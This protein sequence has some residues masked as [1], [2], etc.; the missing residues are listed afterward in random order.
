MV[1]RLSKLYRQRIVNVN[2]N[3]VLAGML[4]LAPTL[5]IVHL[6][7]TFGFTEKLARLLG[8]EREFAINAIT[9]LGDVVCDVGIYYGLHWLANHWPRKATETLH[10]PQPHPVHP[11]FFK[12]A[13]MVQVERMTLSPFLYLLFLGTQHLLIVR[14]VDPVAATAIGAGIG[15]TATRILHTLWMVRQ[16]RRAARRYAASLAA[17]PAVRCPECDRDL[18]AQAGGTCPGCGGRVSGLGG[19]V[20]GVGSGAGV[21]VKGVGDVKP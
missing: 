4:A 20:A 7:T 17:A 21:V 6:A 18:G 10:L 8:I 13:T 14:D 9:F 5:L 1:R 3:I 19:R 11:S 2:V 16:Q 15:I 12:D